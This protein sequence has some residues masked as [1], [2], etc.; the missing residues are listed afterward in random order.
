MHWQVVGQAGGGDHNGGVGF[1]D[2]SFMVAGEPFLF[3]GRQLTITPAPR[4]PMSSTPPSKHTCILR[5]MPNKNAAGSRSLWRHSAR[6]MAN[7]AQCGVRRTSS[8]C[9]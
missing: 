9:E 1:T 5:S 2:W 3:N 8:A 6:A 4:P 7:M